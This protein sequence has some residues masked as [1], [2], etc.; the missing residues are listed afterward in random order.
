MVVWAILPM[1]SMWVVS[2]VSGVAEGADSWRVLG[3]ADEQVGVVEIFRLL[4]AGTCSIWL[5]EFQKCS[6]P[7]PKPSRSYIGV[8]MIH[9]YMIHVIA[10]IT[11]HEIVTRPV[12]DPLKTWRGT[13]I[14]RGDTE[15]AYSWLAAAGFTRPCTSETDAVCEPYNWL[16]NG[17]GK[18]GFRD[19]DPA[20]FRE[21]HVLGGCRCSAALGGGVEKHLHRV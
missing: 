18:A 20:G 17:Q 2:L 12:L 15:V 3:W 1:A 7:S 9:I 5:P 11:K 19:A 4:K 8:Y 13:S 6:S 16:M 10:T 21:G 14:S